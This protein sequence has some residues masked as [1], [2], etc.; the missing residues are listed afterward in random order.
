MNIC[1]YV[2]MYVCMMFFLFTMYVCRWFIR[3]ATFAVCGLSDTKPAAVTAAMMEE[4]MAEQVD[5][6]SCAIYICVYVCMSGVFI[7]P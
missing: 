3:F 1:I 7:Q 6:H 4:A 5:R 2:C